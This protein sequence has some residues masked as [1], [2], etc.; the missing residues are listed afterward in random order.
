MVEESKTAHS[1]GSQPTMD[2]LKKREEFAVS[3]RRQKKQQIISSKRKRLLGSREGKS[4]SA[5]AG[6]TNN[7]VDGDEASMAERICEAT[8]SLTNLL[9]E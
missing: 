6:L 2:P 4:Q 5:A 1:N 9:T 7:A 3:L 8:S